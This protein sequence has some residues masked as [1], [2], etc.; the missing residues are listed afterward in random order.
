MPPLRFMSV[1]MP[2]DH[3]SQDRARLGPE[4][5]QLAREAIADRLQ[6]QWPGAARDDAGRHPQLAQP[7]ATF[8]T[9]RQG[10]ALRGCVG[11]LGARRPLGEDVRENARAAAFLDPRFPPLQ[12]RE[13]DGVS[14][15]V[16]LLTPPQ[17]M[18][19]RDEQDLISQIRPG[20]DGIILARGT[21]RSTFLPQVWESVPSPRRFLALLRK[22][23]G[24]SADFPL[25]DLAVS[26]YEV[27]K[28]AESNPR[29]VAA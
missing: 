16:S 2:A 29:R 15:E 20:V 22:K 27:I 13:F 17:A 14:I 21:V 3:L 19:F 7:G 10:E 23:V 9:L 5:L 6:G 24:L 4:L 28:W 25:T 11:S 8:V 18:V 12:A 1:A 26:R